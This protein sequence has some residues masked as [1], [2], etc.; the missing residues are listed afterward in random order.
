MV[1]FDKFDKELSISSVQGVKAIPDFTES[2]SDNSE[3]KRVE[4]HAH[5]MMSDMDAVV[6]VK[7][8]I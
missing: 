6:D 3:L 5:T 1:M 8:L 4:L 2:R 7:A